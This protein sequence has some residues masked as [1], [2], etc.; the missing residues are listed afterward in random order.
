MEIGDAAHG[1]PLV[2]AAR[3]QL[4]LGILSVAIA[5]LF[6]ALALS[7]HRP[8]ATA[9][10]LL[11]EAAFYGGLMWWFGLARSRRNVG[12]APV[13]IDPILRDSRGDARALVLTTIGLVGLFVALSLV[14]SGAQI[15]AGIALGAGADSIGFHRWLRRWESLHSGEVLRVPFQRRRRGLNVYRIAPRAPIGR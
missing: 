7:G 2:R 8:A 10:G 6:G 1:R 3:E 13:I 12:D 14:F 9:A 4:C 5:V 15:L 11:F